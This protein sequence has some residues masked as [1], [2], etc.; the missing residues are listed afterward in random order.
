M[1]SVY[2]QLNGEH[3]LWL[4]GLG[5]SGVVKVDAPK[6]DFEATSALWLSL[7]Y[8]W[9]ILNHETGAPGPTRTGDTWIRNPLLYP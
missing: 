8:P 5:V 9:T 7:G 3:P 4:D 2:L 6:L 1:A